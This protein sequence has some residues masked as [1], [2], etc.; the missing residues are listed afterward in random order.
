MTGLA[1]ILQRLRSVYDAGRQR[2]AEEEEKRRQA[3][4]ALVEKLRPVGERVAAEARKPPPLVSAYQERQEL[5]APRAAIG[6]LAEMGAFGPIPS[7]ASTVAKAK[8]ETALPMAHFAA[9]VTPLPIEQLAL[10]AN[11]PE[12]EKYQPYRSAG[13]LVGAVATGL[14]ATAIPRVLATG[15]IIGG[16]GTMYRQTKEAGGVLEMVKNLGREDARK[17]VLQGVKGGAMMAA[18]TAPTQRLTVTGVESLAGKIPGLKSLTQGGIQAAAPKVGQALPTAFK[19]VGTA[20]LLRMARAVLLETPVEAFAYG[21]KDKAEGQKLMDSIA[22]QAVSNLVMNV[23]FAGVDTVLDTKTLLPIVRNSVQQTVKNYKLGEEGF[24]KIPGKT[25][26]GEEVKGKLTPEQESMLGKTGE[27]ELAPEDRARLAQRRISEEEAKL[28]EKR[29][30]KPG[31][32]SPLETEIKRK[33]P[34]PMEEAEL[35][36]KVPEA[37]P[38]E[39]PED[40][41]GRPLT[42]EEVES[43]EEYLRSVEAEARIEAQSGEFGDLE[44]VVKRMAR[45][46]RIAGEKRSKETGLLFR[47]HIPR[48]VFGIGSDE[49]S[50]R[51]GISENELMEKVIK[52]AGSVGGDAPRGKTRRKP[53]LK[54]V[55]KVPEVLEGPVGRALEGK[56]TGY[57]FPGLPP[58]T[59]TEGRVEFGKQEPWVEEGGRQVTKTYEKEFGIPLE[60]S[61]LFR[62]SLGRFYAT[63]EG[64]PI[65]IKIKSLGDLQTLSHET[66][67]YLDYAMGRAY[68]GTKANRGVL[69]YN[70]ALRGE[71][72]ALT[73]ELSGPIEGPPSYVKTRRQSRELIAEFVSAYDK[74]PEM[75][76]EHAP[77][78]TKIFEQSYNE[79]PEVKFAVDKLKQW[80]DSFAPVLEFVDAVREIPEITGDMPEYDEPGNVLQKFW[81]RNVGDKIW[82]TISDVTEKVGK[83]KVGGYLTETRGLPPTVDRILRS[84]AKL[85]SG[86]QMRIDQEI[87]DPIAKM[88]KE[89]SRRVAEVLQKFEKSDI[90]LAEEARSEL[91][92]WG[93]EA[94]KLGILN[95]EAFWNRVGQYFPYFY[96]TKE[97]ES[98]KKNLGFTDW[99]KL[100]A[101][102]SGYKRR[103]TDEE[104]GRRIMEAKLG[105]WPSTKEKIDAMGSDELKR[106]GRTGRE[107]MK[108]IKTAAYPLKRRLDQLIQSVYSVKAFN[109]IDNTPGITS[110][111]LIEGWQQLPKT[112]QLGN[113]SGK[114]VNKD[115]YEE[116]MAVTRAPEGLDGVLAKLNQQWK[117]WKVVFNPATVSR[118]IQSNIIAMWMGDVPV[119]NPMVWKRGIESFMTRDDVYKS[120]RDR[121]L[122]GGS[123]TKN[124]LKQM[125]LAV[126]DGGVATLVNKLAKMYN[127]PAK[128]Y[129]AFED[130]S[131]T[132]MARHTLGR[133]A[134]TEQAIGYADKWLFDY[135]RT[136]KAAEAG[137]KGFMP[138][139]TWSAKMFPRLVETVVRKPEKFVLL[140]AAI[141]GA[142]ALS[143]NEL[144]ISQEEEEEQK[145]RWLQKQ[146]ATTILLPW[147]D[148]TGNLQYLDF[149][150][151]S[152][153]GS[154]T[155]RVGDFLPQ[156]L[157]PGNPLTILY[158]AFVSN[159]DPY[160]GEPLAKEW[161]TPQE[162]LQKQT[163]FATRGL[164]PSLVPGGYGW[165]KIKAAGRGEGDYYGRVRDLSTVLLDTLVGVKIQAGGEQEYEKKFNRLESQTNDIKAQIGLVARHKGMSVSAKEKEY[166][167]LYE[168]L[169][170]NRNE[171]L[172]LTGREAGPEWGGTTE[173]YGA[174]RELLASREEILSLII[175]G[176][177]STARAVSEK[178]GIDVSVKEVR[179]AVKQR[180]IELIRMGQ[181]DEAR[182]LSERFGVDVTVDE[183]RMGPEQ[184]LKGIYESAPVSTRPA[185][186]QKL[187]QG[188][189]T[190]PTQSTGVLEGVYKMFPGLRR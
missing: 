43:E 99:K 144:G 154:W 14:P 163:E 28:R 190:A 47:E 151:V 48:S 54:T 182:E 9:G 180:I 13:G 156:A 77:V 120:L 96:E 140:A 4:L 118:N 183:V 111:T 161:E 49:I 21:I 188:Q 94:R 34:T 86:Q 20:G 132:V 55:P 155:Q 74:D 105:T 162:R 6:A 113:L 65:K 41:F 134:S 164:V 98:N 46:L 82:N 3:L 123:Y 93:N 78:F 39:E 174:T 24:A 61:N 68:S 108:L 75:A 84:R 141:T 178:S 179:G 106:L 59:A 146:G 109:M 35:R 31:E 112:K 114:Y 56:G 27:G 19:G 124:E 171:I 10:G 159:Y 104:M 150:Y 37:K 175:E 165:E 76:R 18:E 149:S 125:A 170:R 129:G 62:S 32:V 67:H 79:E 90:P 11:L 42:R 184:E 26:F 176:D 23:G 169:D 143:R 80:R 152:P 102:L 92:L 166:K 126:E 148:N 130:I 15:G 51:M 185:L 136:S 100:R 60:Q 101:D 168:A 128:I 172:Q 153:W 119:Y 22:E 53:K 115:L 12:R 142:N 72:L 145:P 157:E 36:S 63:A 133:G 71:L 122:Y 135:S 131:K 88:T 66:G 30:P 7:M 189:Q 83:T 29:A 177:E 69:S 160:W 25:L 103:L 95:D 17:E 173:A 45:L 73:E 44:P 91:A 158:N 2:R 127:T 81:R 64:E 85:V 121:G 116:L 57:R 147:K 138:F 89:E 167:K 137:R 117:M 50:S 186:L 40:A 1:D 187:S 181:E 38:T 8:P 33:T 16:L 5:G 110:K 97:F 139:I 58:E 107:E 87:V 52:V 70:K